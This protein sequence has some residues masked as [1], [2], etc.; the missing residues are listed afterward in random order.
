M[1]KGI[2]LPHGLGALFLGASG[3]ITKLMDGFYGNIEDGLFEQVYDN[4]NRD[5]QKRIIELMREIRSQ[6]PLLV[7]TFLERIKQ[8]TEDW[9]FGRDAP[10]YLE[11][12]I[13]AENIA[14]RCSEH[15]GAL[16]QVIS[17]RIAYAAGCTP[18]RENLSLSPEKITY[19]F[20]MS[21]R[22]VGMNRYSVMVV[23]DLFHRFVLERLGTV[24][25]NMNRQLMAAGF[26]TLRESSE[27]NVSTA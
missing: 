8:S 27:V 16:L 21:C 22:D 10:E 12:A 6:R 11:E 7:Q 9:L 1:S 2:D 14:R 18:D 3:E 5:E 26:L 4:D 23:Q 15:F 17:E 20:I 19:Q 13:H 24:Y 25:G